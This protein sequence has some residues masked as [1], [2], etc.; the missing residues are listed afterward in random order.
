MP[1]K[2]FYAQLKIISY[3]VLLLMVAASCYAFSM[4]V[5]HWTGINV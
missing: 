5:L 1:Q 2:K 3:V 4:T